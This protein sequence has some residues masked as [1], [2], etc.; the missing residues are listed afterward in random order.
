MNLNEGSAMNFD[1]NNISWKFCPSPRKV[2]TDST[3]DK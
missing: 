1:I 2:V 3:R